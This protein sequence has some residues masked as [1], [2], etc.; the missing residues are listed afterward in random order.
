MRLAGCFHCVPVRMLLVVVGVQALTPD[1]RSLA[2]FK[3]LNILFSATDFLG[4]SENTPDE[5]SGPCRFGEGSTDKRQEVGAM[6]ST[7]TT[8]WPDSRAKL[9][10]DPMRYLTEP[11]GARLE[12]A[13]RTHC[14]L[15]C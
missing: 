9:C 4:D 3:G 15:R 12:G 13:L 1:S 14:R 10:R 7:L 8:G 5:V 6:D 11:N 2:S